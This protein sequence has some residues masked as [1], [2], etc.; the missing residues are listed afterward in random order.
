MKVPFVMG[1]IGGAETIPSCFEEDL[2]PHTLRKER[3]RRKGKDLSLFAWFTKRSNNK[4]IILYSSHQ[5]EARIMPHCSRLCHGIVMPAIAFSKEDF[6]ISSSSD[7][8]SKEPVFEMIYAGKAWDWKGLHIFLKAVKKAFLDRGI[9]DV[10]VRIIGIR[11]KEEQDTVKE[12]VES[13]NISGLV[14]MIPFIERSKLLSKMQSCDLSVYPAFRDSGS[15][16]VLEASAL[17][18]PTIC[19]NVGGQD[20][21]PDNTLFKRE[22]KDNYKD[23]LNALADKLLWIYNNREEA[24]KVGNRAKQ[25]V[26]DNLTWEKRVESFHDIYIKTIDSRGGY[27]SKS[28][29]KI[30][31][32][33]SCANHK[34]YA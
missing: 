31:S 10:K 26:E 28:N 15:M 19:F 30:V 2:T 32:I 9:T 24:A 27:Q 16:S 17:G 8:K 11:F 13:L 1:P 7:N 4:K 21:F 22:V 33:T 6:N 5:N 18:C 3:I 25:F 29:C 20:A 12:W 34:K 14:E 23:T